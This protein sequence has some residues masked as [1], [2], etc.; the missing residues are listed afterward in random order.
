MR[1]HVVHDSLDLPG[2][3]QVQAEVA[4]RIGKGEG[5]LR[6]GQDARRLAFRADV[7]AQG[8]VGGRYTFRVNTPRPIFLN[9]LSVSSVLLT[10]LRN[11]FDVVL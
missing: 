11:S 8:G 5:D 9:R 2:I 6:Y 3:Q 1:L 4:G 10:T 7:A